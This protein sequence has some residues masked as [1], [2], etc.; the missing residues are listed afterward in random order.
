MKRIGVIGGLSNESTLY[1]Y[2]TLIDLCHEDVRFKEDDISNYPE[3]IIYCVNIKEFYPL[4]VQDKWAEVI[5]KLTAT[6]SYLEQAGADFGLISSNTP[7]AV[8]DDLQAN[9]PIPL[10]SI[11]EETAKAVEKHGLR[12]VGL[13]GTKMTMR[14]H[15]Y[16]DV[17]KKHDIG[18]AVPKQ[19]EQDYIHNKIMTELVA[20]IIKNE[21]RNGFLEIAQ[22][23]V[24]EESVEGLILGCTEI[25]ILL[26]KEVIGIPFFDTSK[27]HV[28]S[29]LDYSRSE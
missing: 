2:R 10:I 19:D 3:I 21:T 13:F 28:K 7:H 11:V 24:D 9:S 14:L 22:R 17:F 12:K 4:Y 29:A 8:F 25:P 27:I 1:Y 23:M 15:F 20:G 6:L 5:D 26:N 16:H 18:I